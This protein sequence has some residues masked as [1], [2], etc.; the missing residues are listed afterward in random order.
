LKSALANANLQG[1]IDHTN[2]VRGLESGLAV[3]TEAFAQ[4][5]PAEVA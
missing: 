2:L 3:A 1:V 4:L 5:F